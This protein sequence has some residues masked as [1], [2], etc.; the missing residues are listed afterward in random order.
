MQARQMLCYTDLM[1]R[2]IDQGKEK[3]SREAV[4]QAQTEDQ[5]F[6]PL[7]RRVHDSAERL[8][9]E[10]NG[11]PVAVLLSYE[12]YQELKRQQLMVAFQGFGRIVG[13]AAADQ[14]LGEEELAQDLEEARRAAVKER[15]GDLE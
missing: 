3:M 13:Q 4:I 5:P 2:K 10:E 1:N 14:G 12:E 7:L 8:I 9:V 15:Y 6:G 11:A